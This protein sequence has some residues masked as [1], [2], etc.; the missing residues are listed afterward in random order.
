MGSRIFA[1]GQPIEL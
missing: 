1:R